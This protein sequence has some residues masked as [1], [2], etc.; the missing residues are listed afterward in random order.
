MRARTR[1]GLA[2]T[3]VLVPVCGAAS[4]QERAEQGLSIARNWCPGSYVVEPGGTSG[5]DIA[6]PFPVV[7]QNPLLTPEQLR[8]WLADPHPSMPNLALTRDEIEA[9]VAYFGSLR[10]NSG[11]NS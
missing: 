1:G 8:A 5:N 3:A 4:A 7:A 10:S 11:V 9:L 2:A 6:P